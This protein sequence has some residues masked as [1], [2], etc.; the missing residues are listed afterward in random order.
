MKKVFTDNVV[1]KFIGDSGDGIQLIGNKLSDLSVV[2]SG[3]D[4]YT[5][6]DIPSEIRA[7]IGS[8]S[9]I[10]GFQLSI[11]NKKL[12]SVGEKVDLLV[13][14]NPAALKVGMSSLKKNGILILDLDTFNDRN[15]KR[16]GYI[17]NPVTDSSLNIFNLIKIP[18]TKITYDCVNEIIPNV[19]KARRCKNFFV[20]GLVCWLY[21]RDINGI[22]TWLKSKFKS[23]DIFFANKKVLKAGFDYGNNLELLQTQINASQ[24]ILCNINK[25]KKIS[26]NKAFTLGAVAISMLTKLPLFSA[27]YPITPASDI[28][29]EL[30]LYAC[31]NIKVLQLED[32]ISAINA[33]IGASYGGVL[34]FTCTSGPG[35][36]L[37]QEALGL[38]VITELPILLLNIQRCGPS[39]GIPTKSE[40]TDLLS[41]IFGRHGESSVIVLAANS[42]SDC[43]WTIIEGFIL[44]IFSL[45]PVIIL[46]DANLANSSELWEIP[47]LDVINKYFN[48]NITAIKNKLY[49]YDKKKK[50]WFIPGK[51]GYQNCVGGLERDIKTGNVSQNSINHFN[52]V[53]SRYKKNLDVREKY[54]VLNIIGKKQNDFLI[55]TWGSSYGVVRNVYDNLVENNYKISLLCLRYLNPFPKNLEK[56]IVSFKK[57]LVIEENLG[58]LSFI[59]R[60]KYLI[61]I[62]NI[63]QVTGKPFE[64][65]ILKFKIID[66]IQLYL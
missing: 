35:L 23:S 33:V 9:G 32:E 17:S 26:G 29:H 11:S 6:I 28:L 44:S 51:S 62:I 10:S 12:Y 21:D 7:P 15:L 54:Q 49:D 19:A 50:K 59:L 24:K 41:S 53:K 43:F 30:S 66:N 34:S 4:I 55:I 27:M 47:S 42:P 18:I 61:N 45:S 31:K 57:I 39:T 3:N 38:A 16:A 8:L 58:Q 65:N 48:L 5:F 13:V 60:S 63:N 46:S 56:I 20:L 1:I 64:F 40:Q 2:M 22:I 25:F 52:M 37:M 14:F 36:N